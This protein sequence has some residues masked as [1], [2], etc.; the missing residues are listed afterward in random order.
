[1]FGMVLAFDGFGIQRRIEG[2]LL[3]SWRSLEKENTVEG[4]RDVRERLPID[5]HTVSRRCVEVQALIQASQRFQVGALCLVQLLPVEQVLDLLGIMLDSR[6]V[7]GGFSNG[8]TVIVS[9]TCN[10]FKALAGFFFIPGPCPS[11]SP[12]I[13]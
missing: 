1:M 6:P 7:D 13:S 9:G 4:G 12:H 3:E 11:P 5:R 10:L 2:A 8:L